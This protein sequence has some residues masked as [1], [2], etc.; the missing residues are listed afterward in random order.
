MQYYYVSVDRMEGSGPFPDADQLLEVEEAQDDPSAI[1]LTIDD[2]GAITKVD[3]YVDFVE[4]IR[5]G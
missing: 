1:I 4:D 3:D 5:G 2:N